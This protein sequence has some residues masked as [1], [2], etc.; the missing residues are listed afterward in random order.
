MK[1]TIM[2]IV[3]SIAS[4]SILADP[5]GLPATNVRVTQNE[6]DI[7]LL[8]D[9]GSGNSGDII[10][11]TTNIA[12]NTSEITNNRNGLVTTNIRIDNTNTRVDANWTN[13]TRNSERIDTNSD[14]I[15]ENSDRITSLED[16][17]QHESKVLREE[18]DGVRAM[19]HAVTNARPFIP[20]GAKWSLGTG[21]GVTGNRVALAIGASAYLEEGVTGSLTFSNEMGTYNTHN[22]ASVG[23]GIQWSF[24]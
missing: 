1:T 14:A 7:A 13:I 22:N 8:Q 9:S 3:L 24:K 4:G 2:A 10:T 15:A 23:A 19:A 12:G 18:M 16:Y 6:A 5:G 11:N 17:V 20:S 21:V